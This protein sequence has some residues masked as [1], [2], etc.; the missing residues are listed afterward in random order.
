MATGLV[1]CN[2]ASLCYRKHKRETLK[3]KR[4]AIIVGERNN[5]PKEHLQYCVTSP[6]QTVFPKLTLSRLW[7]SDSW[8]RTKVRQR[9]LGRTRAVFISKWQKPHT[10]FQTNINFVF[11]FSHFLKH[12]MVLENVDIREEEKIPISLWFSL[13]KYFLVGCGN[14]DRKKRENGLHRSQHFFYIAFLS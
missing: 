8:D 3:S 14:V 12:E 4:K 7:G 10:F 2:K 5:T 11:S 6:S 13:G 9:V 1:K